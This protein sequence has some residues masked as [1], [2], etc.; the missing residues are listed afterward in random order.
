MAFKTDRESETKCSI[1]S[2]LFVWLGH[3][4]YEPGMPAYQ[5]VLSTF[6]QD[7]V[8]SEGYIDRR[9]L[10]SRVFSQQV[11]DWFSVLL[12]AFGIVVTDD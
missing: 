1:N 4:S 12:L 11:C 9:Q 5:Q 8:T 6:G 7:L 3:K 10:A 2:F